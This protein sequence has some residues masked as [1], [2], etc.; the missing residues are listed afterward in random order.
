MSEF[1]DKFE[2]AKEELSSEMG[3]T[4]A[5]VVALLEHISQVNT[6]T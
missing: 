2:G 5:R 4:Q 1:I 6:K 3:D